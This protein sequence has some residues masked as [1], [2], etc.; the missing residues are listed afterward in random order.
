MIQI[1]IRSFGNYV[2]RLISQDYGG[3][4]VPPSAGLR[5]TGP[6]SLPSELLSC[7]APR[8]CVQVPPGSLHVTV[9]GLRE[10][11]VPGGAA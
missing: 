7:N 1:Q 6:G 5:A 3:R 10:A 11:A 9:S 2:T 4:G 8:R